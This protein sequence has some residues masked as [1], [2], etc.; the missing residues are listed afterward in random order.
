MLE[1]GTSL[2]VVAA[3]FGWSASTTAKMAKRYGHI[4]SDVQRAAV[5][6]LD[7]STPGV[8]SEPETSTDAGTTAAE[9]VS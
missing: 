2:P 5:A 7:G 6:L 1:R 3:L 4:G 8:T 9:P